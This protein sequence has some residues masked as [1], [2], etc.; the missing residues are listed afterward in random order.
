MTNEQA[1]HRRRWTDQWPP[2]GE[3]PFPLS[4]TL[5]SSARANHLSP[6]L[7]DFYHAIGQEPPREEVKEAGES[8]LQ[9]QPPAANETPTTVPAMDDATRSRLTRTQHQR[10][11]ALA[12]A[13]NRSTWNEATRK[14]YQRLVKLVEQEQ[15]EYGQAVQAYWASQVHRLLGGD[16]AEVLVQAVCIATLPDKLPR[17]YGKCQQIVSL[18]PSE[19]LDQVS[20][21][22]LQ[23]E[24][25]GRRG[26][27]KAADWS[28]L[29]PGSI[30]S[31]PNHPRQSRG[32]LSDDQM[33]VDLANEHHAQVLI[34]RDTL[35]RLLDATTPGS[36]WMV[37]VQAGDHLV[38]VDDPVPQPFASPR[39][40]LQAAMAE[41]IY[42]QIQP[43]NH[44]IDCYHYHLLKVPST[45][46]RSLRVLIRS[47]CRVMDKSQPEQALFLHARVEY[48]AERGQEEPSPLEKALWILDLT[49]G[50]SVAVARVDPLSCQLLAWERASLA[51]AMT[52]SSRGY[53]RVDRH[54][55]VDGW[56]TLVSLLS[57]MRTIGRGQH[58]L[59]YPGRADN[60]RPLAATVHGV[61]DQGEMD[62]DQEVAAVEPLSTDPDALGRCWRPWKWTADRIPYTFPTSDKK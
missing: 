12:D 61:D 23:A 31:V 45:K 27:V 57:A 41:A 60:L 52:E 39:A 35:V 24:L 50:A 49:L 16:Q 56:K 38:V 36:Q 6:L 15:K 18:Q 9:E 3:R 32:V 59:C 28:L 17:R 51:H 42:Q 1:S 44:D 43:D 53:T 37:P 22:F 26:T 62:L 47:Q 19:Q 13:D 4:S 25:V 54:S 55:A 30:L 58:V 33:A 48:F 11:Q 46:S 29:A 40:S 20:L 5:M 2:V 14:E 7:R 8:S 21:S 34:G 10:F